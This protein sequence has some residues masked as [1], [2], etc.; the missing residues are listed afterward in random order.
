ML[1]AF[2]FAA[3]LPLFL[4]VGFSLSSVSSRIPTLIVTCQ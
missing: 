2:F 4:P 1:A 3:I